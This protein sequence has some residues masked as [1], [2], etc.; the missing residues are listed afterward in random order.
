MLPT[1]R[2]GGLGRVGL[3]GRERGS[4]SAYHLSVITINVQKMQIVLFAFLG[5]ICIFL[6][7]LAIFWRN[8]FFYFSTVLKVTKGNFNH[9]FPFN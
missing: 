5:L 8:I 6:H 2:A 9:L 1:T 7:F 3:E 4:P